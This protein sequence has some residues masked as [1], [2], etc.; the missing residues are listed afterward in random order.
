MELDLPN[1]PLIGSK[2]RRGYRHLGDTCRMES[3]QKFW[4]GGN[5]RRKW[6][7]G[8]ALKVQAEPTEDHCCFLQGL[9]SLLDLH[10]GIIVLANII[11]YLFCVHSWMRN[12]TCVI[13]FNTHPVRSDLKVSSLCNM[14]NLRYRGVM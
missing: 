8:V 6:N 11:L 9:L 2:V 3:P 12:F 1:P 10:C 14:R 7:V 5:E 13:S 4:W